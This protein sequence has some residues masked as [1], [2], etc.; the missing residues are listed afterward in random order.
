MLLPSMTLEEIRKEVDKDYEILVRKINYHS[1]DIKKRLS[2]YELEKGYEYY[3]DYLSKYKNKWI[4]R[5]VLD[6]KGCLYS[7]L[8]IYRNYRGH[9]CISPSRT[10]DI[11]YFTGHFF[12][13]Y[14]ERCKLGFTNFNDI[15]KHYMKEMGRF[16]YEILNEIEPGISKIFC[17]TSQGIVLGM[18]NKEYNLIK[19]NTFIP[20]EML[21]ENQA[22]LK[23]ELNFALDKYILTSSILD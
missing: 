15:V 10:K 6:K 9:V 20:N 18:Y 13:R 17:T 7:S 5:L 1:L 22:T 16:N 19:A 12:E 4:C 3:F 11:T 23:N 8:L 14:N 21:T 2:K